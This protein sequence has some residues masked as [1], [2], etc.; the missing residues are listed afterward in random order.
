MLP[1]SVVVLVIISYRNSEIKKSR[2]AIAVTLTNIKS[3][4]DSKNHTHREI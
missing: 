1:L 4:I 2:R 3:R